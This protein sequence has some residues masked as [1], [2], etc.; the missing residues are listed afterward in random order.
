MAT[1]ATYNLYLG[2]DLTVIFGVT[3]PSDLARRAREV[4][5]QV[6]ATD[7][8]R[9]ALAIARVLVREEVDVVGLQEAARWSRVVADGD[10]ETRAEVWLDFLDEL[11]AALVSEG[12]EYDV[13]ACTANFWG[14]AHVPGAG[15]MTVLG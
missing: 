4:H 10:G 1:V 8:P 5:D 11:R 9:R 2:A 15:E 7:F 12:Q 3:D 6:G 13:H 14:G